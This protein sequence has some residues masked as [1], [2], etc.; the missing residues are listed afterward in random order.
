[1]NRPARPPVLPSSSRRK[2]PPHASSARRRRRACVAR[3]VRATG[4]GSRAGEDRR[5]SS[6]TP[7]KLSVAEGTEVTWRYDNSGTDAPHVDAER[8]LALWNTMTLPAGRPPLR[9]C[10]KPPGP[11]RTTARSI[12]SWYGIIRV[13]IA[14]RPDQW[15]DVDDVHDQG[16]DRETDGY[17]VRHPEEAGCR[18]V[19]GMEER[20]HRLTRAVQARVAGGGT[21]RFRSRLHRISSGPERLVAGEEDHDLVGISRFRSARTGSR[22]SPLGSPS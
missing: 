3:A 20:R 17:R 10:S 1:M 9:S 21:W 15:H 5:T 22:A 6:F 14:C 12:H 16:R 8:P 19:E 11:T 2:G 7:S 13:P 18:G 4:A